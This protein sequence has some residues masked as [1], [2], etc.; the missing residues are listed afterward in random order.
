[1][2][3]AARAKRDRVRALVF[4][5]IASPASALDAD[6]AADIYLPIELVERATEI[7]NLIEKIE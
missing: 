2:R 1:M 4:A 6:R 7:D 5:L 3:A